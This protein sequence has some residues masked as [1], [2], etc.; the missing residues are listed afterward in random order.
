MRQTFPDPP[1]VRMKLSQGEI[2]HNSF[3]AGMNRRYIA[4]DNFLNDKIHNRTV[5]RPLTNYVTNKNGEQGIGK[6]DFLP[7]N[8]GFR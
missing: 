6:L 5:I 3:L 1:I 2:G 8:K 7:H 4:V